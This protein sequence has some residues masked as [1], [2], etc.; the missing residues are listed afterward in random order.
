MNVI[1]KTVNIDGK[2]ITFQ[3]GKM[4]KQASGSVL[5]KSGGSAI[6]VTAQANSE[7][8]P[9]VNFIPLTVDYIE[10]MY[11]AGRIPGGFFKREAKPRDKETLNSRLIDRSIRPLFPEGWRC[12]SQI[13]ATVISADPEHPT[14]ALALT[15]ASLALQLSDI[16]FQ[17][18]IAGLRVCKIDDKMVLN[19]SFEAQKEATLDIFVACSKEAIIMVEGGAK[20]ASEAE[21]IDALL[22]VH[23][24]CQVLLSMQDEMRAE[25]GKEKRTVEEA[26]V[27][28]DL[29]AKVKAVA[30]DKIVQAYSI[31][32]KLPRYAALDVAKKE[33]LATLYAEDATLEE[34][35][36]EISEIFSELKSSYVRNRI[37]AEKIR[38][39]ERGLADI[40]AIDCEVS[41]LERTHGSAL[42]TRG[43]TQALVTATLGTRT[44]EQRIDGL[45]GDYFINFML[46]YNFPAFSVG[47]AR[48]SRG[49]GRREIGHGTLAHRALESLVEFSDDFPYTIRLVSEVLESNGSSSMATVCGGSM[50]L[51]NAGVPMKAP[52]AGIAMGLI[53]EGDDIAILSDILGDEDHLGDMDF[54]VAGTPNGI[55]A[56]QMDIKID[57]VSREILETALEQARQG[58]M[59]IL[60]CMEETIKETSTELSD[61]APRITTIQVKQDKIR[62]VIGKGGAVIKDIIAKSGCQVDINDDGV[63]S[64]ASASGEASA[65]AIEMIENITQEPEIGK[66]YMG[67]VQKI[68]DFG[69]F[70]QIFPGTDGLVHISEL[71]HHRVNRVEDVLQ[72]KDEV[73]VKCIG[74]DR[75]KIRLS[76]KAALDEQ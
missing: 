8:K 76:R 20:E 15:G 60:S 46:H 22:Y 55:T 21:V 13:A 14:D 51:M 72:E 29:H 25:A 37:I 33:L 65:I 40:R 18:P 53:K 32:D 9:G 74:F 35:K 1:E 28:A 11:A 52:C 73:V 7:P 3:T 12:E 10:K 63:I 64:I 31:N 41:T 30:M 27:D 70:V 6:L 44:D 48:P 58:R 16:P 42:F 50:A 24:Q 26:V 38:I 56:I 43:E 66:T 67:I 59:H 69:A 57:G 61:F 36:G 34:R 19:P 49:P 39:G 23:D 5:V 47:E 75:G 45:Y 17:G 71:A 2:E 4:A 54:K 62:D 68:T